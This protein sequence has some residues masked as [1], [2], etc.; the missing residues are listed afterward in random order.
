[1]LP[2]NA[3]TNVDHVVHVVYW[4]SGFVLVGAQVLLASPWRAR[5]RSPLMPEVV[6]AV[7]PVLFLIG[8]GFF[9]RHMGFV[10]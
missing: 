8:F 9:G 4:A 1:M 2:E 5:R 7:V 6:W 10:R 3:P